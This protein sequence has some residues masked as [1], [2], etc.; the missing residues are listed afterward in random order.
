MSTKKIVCEC[1][2]AFNLPLHLARHRKS[3]C[4]NSSSTLNDLYKIGKVTREGECIVWNG[5][6]KGGSHS[7]GILPGGAAIFM[8]SDRASRASIAIATGEPVPPELNVL[9]RCDNPPCINPEH[10]YV[11]TQKDNA[12]DMTIRGRSGGR[13]E[14]DV[15]KLVHARECG[16]C[17]KHFT[18]FVD[19]SERKTCGEQSCKS[20]H[21]WLTKP[22]RNFKR[23]ETYEQTCPICGIVKQR[24]V[25]DRAKTCGDDKCRVQMLWKTRKERY[26]ASGNR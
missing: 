26:G 16:I 23:A 3:G 15:T 14:K 22:K 9:H 2:R 21:S 7:Y 19:D 25:S 5:K 1:G 17:G 12:R 10:L 6:R 24:N 11:G 4:L 13:Y 20:E 8:G 18:A